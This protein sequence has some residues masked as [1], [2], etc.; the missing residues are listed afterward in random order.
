MLD[1]SPSFKVVVMGCGSIVIG[2]IDG[3]SND[4]FDTLLISFD[5]CPGPSLVEAVLDF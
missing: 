4:F 2:T 1:A 5:V 3:L